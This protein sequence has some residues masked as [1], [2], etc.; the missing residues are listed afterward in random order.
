MAAFTISEFREYFETMAQQY[1][2]EDITSCLD[3]VVADFQEYSN[4]R[5]NEQYDQPPRK[6]AGQEL[7]YFILYHFA[8]YFLDGMRYDAAIR[9]TFAGYPEI[10]HV[11]ARADDETLFTLDVSGESDEN[12]EYDMG[13]LNSAFIA[14]GRAL[15]PGTCSTEDFINT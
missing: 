4:N 15:L 8:R 3:A 10:T 12:W 11:E 13:Q 1:Q 7:E 2:L 9:Q 6:F 5:Q 14:L